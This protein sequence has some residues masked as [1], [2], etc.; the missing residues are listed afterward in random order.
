MFNYAGDIAK[1]RMGKG[2]NRESATGRMNVTMTAS[3]TSCAP[4]GANLPSQASVRE[5]ERTF[6]D[7]SLSEVHS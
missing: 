2:R 4:L 3:V 6:V 7:L 5:F 1:R